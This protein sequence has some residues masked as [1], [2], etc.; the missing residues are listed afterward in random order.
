[1]PGEHAAMI[2]AGISHFYDKKTPP[3]VL[4]H[5]VGQFQRQVETAPAWAVMQAWDEYLG[6]NS[7]RPKPADILERVDALL[8][9]Y[10]EAVARRKR[11][12]LPPPEPRVID[13]AEKA[14]KD[15]RTAQAI[16]ALKSAA[17]ASKF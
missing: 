8:A 16:A 11:A 12:A 5:A 17:R 13:P 3:E 9:P 2:M 15:A 1:M 4:K 10:R 14:E 6:S 7:Y